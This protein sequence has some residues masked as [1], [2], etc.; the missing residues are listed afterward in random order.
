MA[1][2]WRLA[3][4]RIPVGHGALAADYMSIKAGTRT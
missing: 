3:I 2:C 4:A 1:L